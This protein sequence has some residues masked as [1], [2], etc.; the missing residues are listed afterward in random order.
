MSK[1]FPWGS[2]PRDLQQSPDAGGSVHWEGGEGCATPMLQMLS[3]QGWPGGAEALLSCRF[4][5]GA[6][7]GQ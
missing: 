4:S 7:M 2:V 6:G 5:R 1:G 3:G